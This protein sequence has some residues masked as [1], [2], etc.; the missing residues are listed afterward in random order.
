MIKKY[1]CFTT[2]DTDITGINLPSK[3]NFPFYYEPEEL[4]K[5]AAKELQHYLETQ[6]DWQH[7]FGIDQNMEGLAIG[8]M[9]G[10]L[11]VKTQDGDLGYLSAF[12]GKLANSNDHE[13]FV[14]PVFDILKEDGFYRIEEIE[15]SKL[16]DRLA[17]LEPNPEI[18]VLYQ[19]LSNLS[20]QIEKSLKDV[21]KKIKKTKK[22]RKIE[23][24]LSVQQMDSKEYN[25]LLESMHQTSLNEQFYYRE[26]AV[27]YADKKQKI[28][29]R[30][31]ELTKDIVALK[32]ERK[33]RSAILQQKLFDAYSF[34]NG[35]GDDKSLCDIFQHKLGINP[36]AA[37]GEC[38]APKLLQYAYLHNMT[39]ISM[40]EFWWGS[41]PGSSVRKHGQY[42]P[43]CRG[44]CEPILGHMLEGIEVDINPM[45]TAPIFDEE[46]P[47]VF[48]DEYLMVINKPA[49]FLSVPGI[50]IEDSVFSRIKHKNPHFTG[51]IIVHRL[52]MSTSGL[53]VLAKTK[54]VHKELQKQFVR[55]QVKKRYVAL[56]DGVVVSEEGYIDLPLRVDL[57]NRPHQLVCFEHGKTARTKWEK[58]EVIN[59]KTKVY[60]YPVTGRTHQLRVH[61]SH[62]KG[63]NMS[64]IG[65][66]LYGNRSDR[67]YLHAERLEIVHPITKETVVFKVDADF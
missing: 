6:S 16:N 2:F 35:N 49:E 4:S 1:T 20:S 39:P 22:E 30:Y 14:P 52:D 51:P 28:Q 36:P 67:L 21:K 25:L 54:D 43:A 11:V 33:T 46:I 31:D 34:K 55:R 38:A 45:L 47:V 66:D 57:D 17:D 61:A 8:K 12:S 37:A 9:F 48:E 63:L 44:K 56:L 53:M 7:N 62:P 41:P 59:S 19:Q 27:Y 26:L 5:I 60:F 13:R 3:F 42:Y 23:R 32:E 24:E 64:I 65:D 15:I 29:A 50:N 18:D 10:V 40:A 58:I